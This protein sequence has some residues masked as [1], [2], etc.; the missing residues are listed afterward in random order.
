VVPVAPATN[1]SVHGKL[2]E[3]KLNELWVKNLDISMG[4]VNTNT[5][6]MPSRRVAQHKLP[7]DQF[8]IH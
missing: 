1:I 4:L 3:W 6:A 7:V 5:L 2:V 8:V